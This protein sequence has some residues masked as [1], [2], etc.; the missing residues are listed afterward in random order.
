MKIVGAD[1]DFRLTVGDTLDLVAPF[2]H[3]LDGRLHRLGAAV[4]RQDRMGAGD[5][6]DFLVKRPQLVAAEGARD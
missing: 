4:H 1:D 6:A 2:A 3:R 5:L